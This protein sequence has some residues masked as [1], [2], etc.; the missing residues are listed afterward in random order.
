MTRKREEARKEELE[1]LRQLQLERDRL[2]KEERERVRKENELLRQKEE[3]ENEKLK[4]QAIARKKE[5]ENLRALQLEREQQ[6]KEERDRIQ[7]Q[8]EELE[9][10]QLELRR[11]QELLEQIRK[12]KER[13]K[14][15]TTTTS[16]PL[17]TP[18]AEELK[19]CI[20]NPWPDSGNIT[21]PES[22]LAR[23]QYIVKSG[24]KCHLNCNKGF[25]TLDAKETLCL[26][27]QWSHKLYCVLPGALLVVGGRSDTYGVLSSVEL[28]TSG[29]VCRNIVP[30]LPTMRWKMVSASIDEDTVVACGGINFLGDPK[31]HCWRLD[32]S[33]SKPKWTAM[34]SLSV[35]RDAAAWAAEQGKLYVM[36][37]LWGHFRDTPPV[38]RC[39]TL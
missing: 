6:L 16:K 35:P 21:C 7:K 31:T 32:F 23:G 22:P 13:I 28:V 12:E 36:G 4:Q 2:L 19:K 34:Q 26:N 25:V 27:G 1:K 9:K 11:Q 17:P 20:I 30:N 33:Y 15:T 39:M 37:D 29:G 3:E 8:K 24:N 18:A 10:Q 5:I 14:Q 38:L